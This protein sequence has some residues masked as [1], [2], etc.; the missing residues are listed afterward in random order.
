VIR[1]LIA[2]D[3]PMVRAGL[4]QIL[5]EDPKI[6]EIGEAASGNQTLSQLRM[7]RWNV[8]LL[9]INMPDRSG[10]DILRNVVAGFPHTKVLIQSGFAERMYALKVLKAGASGYLSKESAPE[11]LLTAV[12]TV[13]KGRRYMSSEVA[14]QLVSTLDAEVTPLAHGGL[15]EREFQV[16][17]KIA[18]GHTMSSIGDELCLS[19][20]TIS[21]YRSRIL[22]KMNFQS[23]AQMT[24]YAVQNNLI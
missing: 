3:H 22:E 11:Q 10:L 19:V 9:D 6:T 21:T 15:S 7:A 13:I 16:F 23:N 18:K 4:R 20:K 5:G 24:K 14:E 12:H 1:V 17:Y 8:L 2:D